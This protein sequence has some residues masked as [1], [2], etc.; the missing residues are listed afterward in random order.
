MHWP[1]RRHLMQ[2]KL[3]AFQLKGINFPT[4]G[5][6]K[7]PGPCNFPSLDTKKLFTHQVGLRL[8]VLLNY[9]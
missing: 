1:Q 3:G 4:D 7:C 2:E 6:T 9:H 8:N 5:K